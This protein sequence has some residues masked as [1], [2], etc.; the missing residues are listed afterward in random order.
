MACGPSLYTTKLNFQ[1]VQFSCP[2]MSES[3]WSHGLQHS[4]LPCPSPTP[5]VCSGDDSVM[6]STISSSVDP[7]SSHLQF[8]P[9]SGSFPMSWLFASGCQSIGASAS[10]SVLLMNI[11]DWFPSGL[12]GLISLQCKGLWRV[13][14]NSTV[15]SINS[16]VLSLLYS[17]SLT[18][19]HDDW[20]NHKFY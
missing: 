17:P 15:Q 6:P 10:A 9:A 8:F 18:S 20:K 13:F 7:R 12:T 2:V 14:S 5:R 11:Q 19:L 4:R 16:T 3:L 1:S